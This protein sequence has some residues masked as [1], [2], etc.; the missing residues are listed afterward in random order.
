MNTSYFIFIVLF[1]L[2]SQSAMS[3]GGLDQLCD[4]L[5]RG[6]V[7]REGSIAAIPPRL[8]V[9]GHTVLPL[10]FLQRSCQTKILG[11]LQS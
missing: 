2:Q 4:Q 10:V 1:L 7:G 5:V 9:D 8:A 3:P 6:E 11:A